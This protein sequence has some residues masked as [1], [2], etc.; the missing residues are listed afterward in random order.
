MG[1]DAV[2]V[3]NAL[4]IE[5]IR[6]RLPGGIVGSRL[7]LYD[8]VPSTNAALREMARGGAPEGTVVLADTQTAGLGRGGKPWFSPPGV[9][10]YAS[11]LLRPAIRPRDAGV[12]SMIASLAVADGV[13]EVGLPAAIKWPND[14]LIS[15]KKVCGVLAEAYWQGT[16]LLGVVLGIG[17]NILPEAVPAGELLF[18]ATSVAEEVPGPVNRWHILT[19]VLEH[20]IRRRA[21]IGKTDFLTAWEDRLAYKGQTVVVGGQ[22]GLLLGLT[23]EG[24]LRLQTNEGEKTFAAGEVSLRPEISL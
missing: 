15:G 5:R 11:V 19:M 9:N 20:L 2:T 1:E 22:R 12:F 14:V 23:T 18:P 21:R 4:S 7:L 3:V 16:S 10:L 13:G 17:I 6:D 24:S 8:A